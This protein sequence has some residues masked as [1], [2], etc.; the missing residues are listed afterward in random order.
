MLVRYGKDK[1][2]FCPVIVG[3][4]D[5]G[6]VIEV[7]LYFSSFNGCL[8]VDPA[9][10]VYIGFI[11][12]VEDKTSL[13]ILE[14][15]VCFIYEWKCN[16][17]KESYREPEIFPGNSVNKDFSFGENPFTFS[18]VVNKFENVPDYESERKTAC[19]AVRPRAGSGD[20]LVTFSPNLPA[21]RN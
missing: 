10:L 8:V 11:E 15:P 17:I 18:V 9:Q 13:F 16:Y 14:H 20:P 4:E 7:K 1:G 19:L 3:A 2:I 21:L 12:L 5:V 6:S